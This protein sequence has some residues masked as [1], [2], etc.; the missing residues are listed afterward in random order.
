MFHPQFAFACANTNS[1]F[2][3]SYANAPV[4]SKIA[5]LHSLRSFRNGADVVFHPQFA[6]AYA[7][8]NSDFTPSYAN[9]KPLL[10]RL[11]IKE[12][13]KRLGLFEDIS[14]GILHL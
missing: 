14:S 12:K 1:D 5:S 8:A 3:P 2:T 4:Q 10:K 7:N 11:K 9:K 6:F 13:G